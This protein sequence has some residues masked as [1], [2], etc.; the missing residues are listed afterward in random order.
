MYKITLE[1]FTQR[2]FIRIVKYIMIL[3]EIYA[4]ISHIM[5]LFFLFLKFLILFEKVIVV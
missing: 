3:Y 2:L 4:N 5:A 1:L